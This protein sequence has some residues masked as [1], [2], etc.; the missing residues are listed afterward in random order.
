[1]EAYPQLKASETVVTL[2][3]S[4]NEVEAQIAAA[5]RTFNASVTSY[6]T[7]IET[8]PTNLLAGPFGFARRQVFEASS[9]DRAV[10]GAG[11]SS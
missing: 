10:P 11:L 6:N 5:R 3:R 9:T 1:M 4:L 2:Q 7:L 8:V